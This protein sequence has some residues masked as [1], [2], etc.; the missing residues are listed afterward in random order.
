[1]NRPFLQSRTVLEIIHKLRKSILQQK[2]GPFCMKVILIMKEFWKKRGWKLVINSCYIVTYLH[3][4]ESTN[5]PGTKK[6]LNNYHVVLFC[7]MNVQYC[8]L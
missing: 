1:M 2:K 5:F 8:Q 4:E 7:N 6:V 3:F